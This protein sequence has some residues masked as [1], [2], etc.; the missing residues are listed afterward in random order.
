[1]GTTYQG[2]IVFALLWMSLS[3]PLLSW[4]EFAQTEVVN[5]GKDTR[6]PEKIRPGQRMEGAV[7]ENED[8]K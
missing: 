2:V 8:L 5:P 1:M 7:L 6:P 3:L 4:N